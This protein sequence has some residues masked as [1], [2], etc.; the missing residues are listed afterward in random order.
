L[1]LHPL[2]ALESHLMVLLSLR[3]ESAEI[4]CQAHGI[5][6]EWRGLPV[7][8]REAVVAVEQGIARFNLPLQRI[9]AGTCV[10]VL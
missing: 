3:E 10:W 2:K 9:R 5:V 6:N 7:A 1:L 4:H 8:E